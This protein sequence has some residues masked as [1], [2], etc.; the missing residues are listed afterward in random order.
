[1]FSTKKGRA[2]SLGVLLLLDIIS[3]VLSI[4]LAFKLRFG[5]FRDLPQFYQE[6]MVF[7]IL[8][9]V[10]AAL[11]SNII[12]HC[13]SAVWR[14]FGYKD[15]LRQLGSCLLTTVFIVLVD[16]FIGLML[17]FELFLLIPLFMLLFMTLARFS[18]RIWRVFCS[19]PKK[20]DLQ[21][22][23]IRTLIYGAGEAGNYLLSNL[24]TKEY[25]DVFP[26]GFVDDDESLWGR[27]IGAVKVLG[28]R[29]RLEAILREAEVQ[30][31]IVAIPTASW[32][33]L[34]DIC[35][36]CRK[37]QVEVK[38]YGTLE[39]VTMEDFR[40]APIRQIHFEDLLRR[41]SI[42]LNMAIVDLFVR[43]KTVLV[44]GGVGSIGSEICL[45][46][47]RFGAQKV[48]VFDINE[49]GLFDIKNELDSAGESGRFE[50]LL[51]SVRDRSRLREVFEEFAPQVVFHAAAHKHVP[52][53][54]GNPKEAVKNNVLG[55]INVANEA[56]LHQV[57]KCILI[58]T[59]KAVNPTNIMGATKRIAEIAVQTMNC[60]GE[61]EFAAVRFGNVL[62]S[63][64][65]VVPFFTKQIEKG[66]PVTVTHPE[67]KRY[68][69]TIPEAV[70][71]VLE[72]GAM[73]VGG[74]IFVL[75]MGEPIYIYDLACDLIRLHGLE[76]DR[77]IPIQITGLRPGEK[78]FE[79]IS[80]AEEDTTKTPN[81]KIFIN[82]PMEHDVRQVS[83][84]IR[85]L[86][87]AVQKNEM[88]R[89]FQLIRELVPTF[90]HDGASSKEEDSK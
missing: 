75:D 90:R 35:Q 25:A 58:S 79:E 17:P 20:R 87:D 1:M 56:I 10:L 6:H 77:D 34:K 72:A 26:V 81:N 24:N 43:G 45:Q 12:V 74:E 46:A 71:L 88:D 70:Q 62:G 47:L 28:G 67:M 64:G 83:L 27:E 39:D 59:D 14:Y 32:E 82:K 55:T 49:N 22:E 16:N 68:F 29:V 73:A 50:V 7:Y 40:R 57:E 38:R 44:T 37:Y 66:G 76:P 42:T 33:F 19:R 4:T 86:S 8:L 52:M 15:F 13:Y 2:V 5:V 69:M 36:T 65:S 78:L 54:E 18:P 80:L 23:G 85:E 48:L 30:E 84:Q 9:I 89:M 41:D 60:A 21:R 63:N 11:M 53:M 3:V 31:V 51:G 61:T